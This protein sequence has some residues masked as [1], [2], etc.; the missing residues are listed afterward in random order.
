MVEAAGFYALTKG[1]RKVLAIENPALGDAIHLLP[2]LKLLRDNYPQAELHVVAGPPSFFRSVAPWIDRPWPQLER[3]PLDNRA[4]RHDLARE[5]IDVVYNFSGHNRAGMLAN[6][7][8]ARWKLGRRTDQNKPWWWQPL[9]YTATVDYPW[10]REPMFMQHWQLL[11]HCGLQG[12]RQEYAARVQP[13]WYV[14]TGLTPEER[15][16]YLHVSPYYS[17]AGKELPQDQYIQLIS[18]LQRKYERVILSCG[19]APREQELLG[20]LVERMPL[21]PY[22]VFPG[23]LT[24]NQFIGLI[25]GARLHLSGDSG[26]LHVARMVGTPSVCWYRR[27]WDYLNWAPGPTETQHRVVFTD[28]E[29]EDA[30]LGISNDELLDEVRALL[31]KD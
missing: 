28:D 8:G 16:T 2:A 15:K 11:K 14:E 31:V 29:S 19:P 27:R 25:D 23:N 6:L 20:K 4:L 3:K 12:E 24:V 21:P 26:S 7:I 22:K 18:R 13:Q 30:C 1:A 10:H 9:L 17:F 5:K